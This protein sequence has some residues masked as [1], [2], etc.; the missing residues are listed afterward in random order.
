MSRYF[1]VIFLDLYF[2]D[3]CH[4]TIVLKL[5]NCLYSRGCSPL[6]RICYCRTL[7]LFKNNIHLRNKWIKIIIILVLETWHGIEISIVVVK[8][9]KYCIH[10]NVF[11]WAKHS[12]LLGVPQSGKNISWKDIFWL[13]RAYNYNML[14]DK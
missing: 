8:K 9:C 4:H 7:F 6:F 3:E 14:S 12:N 2:I 10:V 13:N 5:K 1:T 11:H